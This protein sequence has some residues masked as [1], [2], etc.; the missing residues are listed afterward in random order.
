MKRTRK[1]IYSISFTGFCDFLVLYQ[2]NESHCS[3]TVKTEGKKAF[4]QNNFILKSFRDLGWVI[5]VDKWFFL[6][7][8]SKFYLLLFIHSGYF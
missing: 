8:N 7:K 1:Y 2:I 4:N 3:M 6:S 5:L